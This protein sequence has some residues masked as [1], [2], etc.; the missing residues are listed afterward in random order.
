MSALDITASLRRAGLV[1][2]NEPVIEPLTGGVSSEILHVTDGNRSFVVKRALA[3][4]KVRDDW[5]ADVSRNQVEENYL[6]RVAQITPGCVPRVLHSQADE[7]WFAMEFLG[8]AFVNWKSEL[9]E[10]RADASHAKQAGEILGQIHATTWGDQEVAQEFATLEN[11]RQLRLEPYLETTAERV[12]DLA[13]LLRA[14]KERLAQTELCLVHGDFSP[15]NIL[16]SPERMVVVDAEV[17]W[18]GDPVFDTAFLLTHFHLKA[19]LHADAPQPALSL[20]P[21]FWQAYSATLGS[22][23]DAD[24]EARTVRLVLCLLLARV[25]GKSPV[26]YLTE[27]SQRDFLTIFVRQHLPQPPTTLSQLT[28]L[29]QEGISRL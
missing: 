2:S 11:F 1:Q 10:N 16:I 15:K 4:L 3:K 24:L 12:T 23:A 25:H 29:W 7:G 5:F 17:G 27:T 9:I 26:E 6:R 28:T 21:A 8:G 14:E 22:H 13:L 19:L 20:V 18:F